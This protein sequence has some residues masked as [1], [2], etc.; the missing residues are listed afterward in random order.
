MTPRL[1][2]MA[3]PALSA[4]TPGLESHR[5]DAL[6]LLLR[7][8]VKQL[9]TQILNCWPTCNCLDAACSPTRQAH[10]V[11]VE[12]ATVH[13]LLRHERPLF[14][15]TEY[16]EAVKQWQLDSCA[17]ARYVRAAFAATERFLAD[18]SADSVHQRIDLMPVGIG[19]PT[20]GWVISRFVVRE[21]SSACGER[22]S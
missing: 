18:L 5:T 2:S 12:D 8:Q 4:G 16:L 17:F 1:H 21:L 20:V 3:T 22:Q 15:T 14:A 10:V 11:C 19:K 6:V 13:V 9:H 7:K